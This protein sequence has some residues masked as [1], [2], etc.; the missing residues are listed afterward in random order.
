[1]I[2]RSNHDKFYTPIN[3]EII[4][5]TRMSDAAFRLL[6]FMLSCADKWNFSVKGLAY[7]MNWSERKVSKY[8]NELKKLG[9]IVQTLQF[10]KQGHFMPAIW[11]VHEEPVTALHISRKAVSTECGV[12]AMRLDRSA[13]SPQCGKRADITNNNLITKNN[14][15][16][17]PKD[18]K[19][20]H[21]EFL[22]VMLTSEEFKKLEDKLGSEV[23][24]QL[25]FELSCYIQ[26]GHQN[27]YKD[28]YATVLA[29]SRKPGRQ[30]AKA[31][32]QPLKPKYGISQDEFQRR[33]EE[34]K[35]KRGEL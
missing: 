11:D 16:Q 35:K 29:W 1:M 19:E 26:N 25:I 34:E 17:I 2:H 13:V 20:A 14:I 10:D 12:N 23:R 5:D 28:H 21:G 24:D 31:Q 15:K 22:N 4:E 27:K 7:C 18:N 30:K 33:V 32:T 9:Y 3:N 6:V 8:V